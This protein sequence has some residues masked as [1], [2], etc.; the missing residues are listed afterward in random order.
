M[1]CL[2]EKICV[3]DK[4]CLGLGYGAVGCEF[5]VNESAM[6]IKMPFNR[7]THQARFYI[8]QL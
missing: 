5:N 7:N 4:L 2:T 6:Y 3:L 1:M 8:N